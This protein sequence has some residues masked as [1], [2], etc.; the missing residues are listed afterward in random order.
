MELPFSKNKVDVSTE[1]RARIEQALRTRHA[2]EGTMH[3]RLESAAK[4]RGEK[5][6]ARF[7]LRPSLGVA[8]VSAAGLG[9]AMA[10]GVG[11]LTIAIV[12]GYAAYQ[13]LREGVPPRVAVRKAVEDLEKL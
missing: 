6:W 7:K 4:R 8:L 3:A 2:A 1:L 10:I 13:V 5:L 12:A 11:E 9:L